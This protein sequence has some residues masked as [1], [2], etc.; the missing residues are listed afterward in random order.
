MS[1]PAFNADPDATSSPAD[2]ALLR[3]VAVLLAVLVIGALVVFCFFASSLCITVVLAA[4]LAILVDPLVTRFERWRC[5]RSVSAAL[6]LITGICA[7]A[8]LSY[9]YY[10]K[11]TDFIDYIPQYAERL[12]E[13]VAPIAQKIEKVQ[14]SASSLTPDAGK[15]KVT[16]V[17]VREAPNWP[18]FLVRGF[19]S[20]WGGII[21]AGVVPF[22]TFF[23]LLR[24]PQ[25]EARFAGLF[26]ERIDV[27]NFYDRIAEMVR[28]F[29]FGN[30]I[31]GSLMAGIS[32][33]VFMGLGLRSGAAIGI[34]SGLLNLVPFLGVVLAAL[35]PLMAALLQYDTVTPYVIIL[36]TVLLL[37]VVSA[38]ILI[39]KFIGSRV[40]I[41]PVAATVGIL[42]WGWLWG[43]IGLLL[44]IPLT[45]L[46]KI[47]ADCNPSLI[48]V[49]NLLAESPRTIPDWAQYGGNAID[50]AIPF[51][52]R[53]FFQRP[54]N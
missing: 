39:P 12:R 49:S 45:A 32:V 51:L 41:G 9:A 36:L 30:L 24:K 18:N 26:G 53:R 7:L 11:V 14:E 22:L 2:N 54:Q 21:I 38:N 44:A 17:R 40:K 34:A 33:A 46:I 27:V 29:V 37:H 25:M 48:H 1:S 52:R 28:G 23:M 47:I 13:A 6:I 10:G 5:P 50:R 35:L 3:R 31:V 20:V 8:L 16:E 15:K 43:A 42:F 4:F 19:G